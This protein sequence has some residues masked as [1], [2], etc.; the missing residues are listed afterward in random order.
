M[1]GVEIKRKKT[2][3]V[4]RFRIVVKIVWI[5]VETDKTQGLERRREHDRHIVRRTK[6]NLILYLFIYSILGFQIK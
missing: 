1:F 6:V 3:L 5:D 2:Y 4:G